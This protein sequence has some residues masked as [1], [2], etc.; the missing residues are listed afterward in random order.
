MHVKYCSDYVDFY[1]DQLDYFRLI[2]PDRNLIFIGYI[3]FFFLQSLILSFRFANR[4]RQANSR[5]SRAE[6]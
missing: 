5:R 4:F 1:N 6:S 2:A 3:V